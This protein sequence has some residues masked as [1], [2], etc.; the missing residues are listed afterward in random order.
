MIGAAGASGDSP[1]LTDTGDHVD[2]T[3]GPEDEGLPEAEES[4]AAAANSVEQALS[5]PA[6]RVEPIAEAAP[7]PPSPGSPDHA[8]GTAPDPGPSPSP[9][10]AST[11]SDPDSQ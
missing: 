8:V 7:A 10:T 6:Q 9:G 5:T 3:E 1:V 11:G 4:H 2:A